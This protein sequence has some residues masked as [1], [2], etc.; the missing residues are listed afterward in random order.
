MNISLILLMKDGS[1]K[2]FPVRSKATILGRRPECDLLIPLQVV[3]RRHCQLSQEKNVL[4]IRDLR[5]SNGTFLNGQKVDNESEVKA[6][7]RLQDTAILQPMPDTSGAKIEDMNKSG[8]F[9]G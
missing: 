9:T 6:G 3:S 5:S 8:T 4:K 1:K 2:V 7:D